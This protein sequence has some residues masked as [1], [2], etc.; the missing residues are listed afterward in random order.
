MEICSRLK[1]PPGKLFNGLA[2][3][4]F[5]TVLCCLLSPSYQFIDQFSIAN[6][7]LAPAKLILYSPLII[8]FS[9]LDFSWDSLVWLLWFS[10]LLIWAIRAG[11]CLIKAPRSPN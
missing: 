6:I 10:I 3:F 2:F 4:S 7:I 5:A 1:T 11:Y 9:L 8:L